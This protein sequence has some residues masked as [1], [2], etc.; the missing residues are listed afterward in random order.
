MANNRESSCGVQVGS[1][2]KQ[3]DLDEMFKALHRP[4]VSPSVPAASAEVG[5]WNK[6]YIQ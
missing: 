1:A 2:N 3:S 4:D 5:Q 6:N